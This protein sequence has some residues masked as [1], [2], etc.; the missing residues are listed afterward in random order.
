MKFLLGALGLLLLLS[1]GLWRKQKVP[2]PPPSSGVAALPAKSNK[3]LEKTGLLLFLEGADQ[4]ERKLLAHLPGAEQELSA[5]E[6]ACAHCHGLSGRGGVWQGEAVPGIRAEQLFE[7]AGHEGKALH[8]YQED[9]L[10]RLLTEGVN[11]EGKSLSAAMPRYSLDDTQWAALYAYLQSLGQG[12]E[13]GL[14]AGKVR[15]GFLQNDE[16]DPVQ[17]AHETA[18]LETLEQSFRQLNE[19]GGLAGR[20]LELTSLDDPSL[21]RLD[22]FFLLLGYREHRS[23]FLDLLETDASLPMLW[24]H[25]EPRGEIEKRRRMSYALQPSAYDQGRIAAQFAKKKLEYKVIAVVPETAE[26]LAWEQGAR[27]ESLSQGD[28][29]MVVCHYP[30][31][32]METDDFLACLHMRNNRAFAFLGSEEDL[33]TFQDIMTNELLETPVMAFGGIGEDPKYI[34]DRAARFPAVYWTTADLPE[35]L[36][37]KSELAVHNFFARQ[38]WSRVPLASDGEALLVAQLFEEIFKRSQPHITRLD[39]IAQLEQVR[40]FHQSF[41]PPLSFSR[42]KKVGAAGARIVQWDSKKKQSKE[43]Q[44]WVP[45]ER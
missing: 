33:K 22:N 45:V 17:A 5:E 32:A 38:L 11:A 26:G 12:P 2:E 34:R 8:P 40:D 25:E 19:Q 14:E 24:V 41:L 23:Q 28:M 42:N 15:I 39:W 21:D 20:R 4:A 43:I 31:A 3:M 1:L 13:P 44:S 18:F 35:T 16:T 37:E 9:T 27:D 29:L 6:A 10:R 7:S 30:A 36:R